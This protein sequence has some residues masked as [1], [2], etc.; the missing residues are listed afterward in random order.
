MLTSTTDN[1]LSTAGIHGMGC[2][3]RKGTTLVNKGQHVIQVELNT[4]ATSYWQV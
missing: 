3:V 1:V 4:M 2:Y